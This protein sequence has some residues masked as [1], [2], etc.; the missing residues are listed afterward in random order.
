VSGELLSNGLASF[1]AL[2]ASSDL[3]TRVAREVRAQREARGLSLSAAAARAGVSRTILATIEAG[4][5][6][7]SLET[8]SR[9]AG[10]LDITVGAL[11]AE[12]EP[13]TVDLIARDA[14]EWLSFPSGIRGRLIHVDGRD[15][16]LELLEIRLEAGIRYASAAH[17]PGTEEFV[18]CLTG[19]LTV[20]PEG[21]EIRLRR[22]DAA[23]FAADVPHAYRS[24]AGASA[25]CC[26]TYPAVRSR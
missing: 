7:P 1:P 21:R 17:A 9:I 14:T 18:I 3:A 6:N 11:L 4:A 25:L 20:G 10:A 13:L 19:T 5:G 2:D 8:L 15:R 12:D 23:H 26:F 16:R 22:G 24:G